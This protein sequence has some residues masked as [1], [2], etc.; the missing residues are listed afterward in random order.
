MK[1]YECNS[2]GIEMINTFISMNLNIDGIKVT[3]T[4]IPAEEC[5]NC[6]E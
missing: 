1:C 4:G 6:Y 3:I 5:H 2:K